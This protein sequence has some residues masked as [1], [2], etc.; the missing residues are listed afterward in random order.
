MEVVAAAPRCQLLLIVLMAVMLLP[1]MKGSPL[2]VQRTV[3]R[4]IVLQ[5]TIGKGTALPNGGGSCALNHVVITRR[6]QQPT[7]RGHHAL[8]HSGITR[9]RRTAAPYIEIFKRMTGSLNGDSTW[10]KPFQVGN[11]LGS[12]K[13]FE[14]IQL[15]QPYKGSGSLVLPH[16][17]SS[18]TKLPPSCRCPNREHGMTYSPL[19]LLR[20]GIGAALSGPPQRLK[21]WS[22]AEKWG[23]SEACG[24]LTLQIQEAITVWLGWSVSACSKSELTVIWSSVVSS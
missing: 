5:E 17:Q 24:S 18:S 1:G 13:E 23:I 9:Q 3:T 19:E 12:S 22:K 21:R 20:A 14:E 4:T 15:S 16:P 6:Q 8:L 10:T 2:L 11:A 7:S